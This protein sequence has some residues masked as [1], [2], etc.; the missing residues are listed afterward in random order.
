[1]QKLDFIKLVKSEFNKAIKTS[2][3]TSYLSYTADEKSKI[4]NLAITFA[5]HRI[6]LKVDKLQLSLFIEDEEVIA[7]LKKLDE[8]F[9]NQMKNDT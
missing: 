1:M 6:K 4:K 2:Q 9:Y 8:L 7:H 3:R 5:I